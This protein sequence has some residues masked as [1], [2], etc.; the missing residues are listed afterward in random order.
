MQLT[1]AEVV[2]S[3]EDMEQAPVEVGWHRGKLLL[4]PISM[5][6]HK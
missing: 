6:L 5:L 2:E 3:D 4:A 1:T